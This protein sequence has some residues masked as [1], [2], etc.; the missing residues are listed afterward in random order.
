MSDAITSMM[1]GLGGGGGAAAP[2][3]LQAL[4]GGT[5][6]FGE[7]G[8][9]LADI[10][11]SKLLNQE[12]S[13]MNMT[14]QQMAAKVTAATQPL[15]AGLT[16][17]VG[18]EVQGEMG[19]RGLAQAPGI[20]A[21][22]ESQALAPFY[23]QNQ[24]QALQLILQQ[25]GIP[26]QA[27]SLLPGMTNMAPLLALLL[28]AQGG[29]GGGNSSLYFGGASP[30]DISAWEGGPSQVP[31]TTSDVGGTIPDPSSFDPSLAGVSG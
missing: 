22:T 7:V 5:A 2:G 21:A 12:K 3:W 10:Q 24:A 29:G 18:N 11:R 25:M 28:R 8:N 4:L 16:Q 13:W 30:T 26:I 31:T 27:A 15:S 14:P 1:G 20:F 17:A 6:G 9:I 19:E 23:Q